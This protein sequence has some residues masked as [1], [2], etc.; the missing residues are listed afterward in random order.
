MNDI[1][2]IIHRIRLCRTSQAKQLLCDFLK[3]LPLDSESFERIK[4]VIWD[5]KYPHWHNFYNIVN[6]ILEGKSICTSDVFHFIVIKYK[7][8][9]K[10]E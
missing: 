5:I 9:S 4:A 8:P 10:A 1:E 3:L 7:K 2:K 6:K